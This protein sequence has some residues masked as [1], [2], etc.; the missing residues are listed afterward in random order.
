MRAQTGRIDFPES[1]ELF[2]TKTSFMGHREGVSFFRDDIFLSWTFRLIRYS[3]GD[4]LILQQG[5]NVIDQETGAVLEV[6]VSHHFLQ[7]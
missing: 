1:V 4:Q 2:N 6:H 3:Q 5:V 7:E